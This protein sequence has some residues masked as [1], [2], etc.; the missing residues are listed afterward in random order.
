MQFETGS[1]PDLAAFAAANDLRH[2]PASPPPAY[3]GAVFEYLRNATVSDRVSTTTGPLFEVGTIEGSLGGDQSRGTASGW[4]VTTS[5]SSTERRTYGYLA[6]QLERFL[7]QLLLDSTRNDGV[8]GSSIPM[9]IATGQSLSLEG[10]FNSHFTLYAPKGYERDALYVFTPDLMALLIDETGDFDV[11]IVDDM[12]FVYSTLAF[13]TT[14]AAVWDRI[15]RI[16]TVLGAKALTQTDRYVDD[17]GAGQRS[18]APLPGVSAGERGTRL[19]MGFAGTKAGGSGRGILALGIGTAVGV[20][21]IIGV[22]GFFVL[23][24]VFGTP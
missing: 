12:L 23:G 10:D 13:D 15:A 22:V 24:A 17:R 19:Q 9:P 5:F 6:M 3:G 2:T 18:T 14:D 21:A 11:E 16:R 20:V 7:P 1:L 8:F 4:T